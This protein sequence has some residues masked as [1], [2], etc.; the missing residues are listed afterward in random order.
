MNMC[1]FTGMFPE[2]CE[3]LATSHTQ[4]GSYCTQHLIGN[5]EFYKLL[6]IDF[7]EITS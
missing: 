3:H 1:E 6:G 7:V 2:T 4:Y 5:I